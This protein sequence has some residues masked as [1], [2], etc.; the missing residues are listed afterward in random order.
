MTNIIVGIALGS[1]ALSGGGAAALA[2]FP[3]PAGLHWEFVTQKN[4]VVTNNRGPVIIL[5]SN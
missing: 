3:A 1:P 4:A 5:R 2:P